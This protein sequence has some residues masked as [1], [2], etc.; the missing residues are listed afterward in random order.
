MM[1]SSGVSAMNEFNDVYLSEGNSNGDKN[2]E[3]PNEAD[4]NIEGKEQLA[5]GTQAEKNADGSQG[6][7]AKDATNDN[8]AAED[9]NADNLGADLS[10]EEMKKELEE[11]GLEE[12]EQMANEI[13]KMLKDSEYQGQVEIDFTSQY[14]CLTLNGA[15][16]FGSG[17]AELK[18]EAKPMVDRI[19]EVLHEYEDNLIDVEGH[20][21]NVPIHNSRFN[22]NNTLST[23]RALAVAEYLFSTTDLKPEKFKYSGRGEYDP[24]GDNS[25]EEGRARNRR[26]EIKVYNS[27]YTY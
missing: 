7:D 10:A 8:Q 21:D 17:E 5:D 16:L 9:Q 19:G 27:V 11:K 23:F 14:V 4:E 26:V 6:A 3:T 2:T 24:V 15:L 12:S 25:T 13:E 1:I 22:D 20:T 18:E